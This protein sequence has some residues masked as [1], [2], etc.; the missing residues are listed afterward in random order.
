MPITRTVALVVTIG[1][2]LLVA[3]QWISHGRD[4]TDYPGYGVGLALGAGGAIVYAG[5]ILANVARVYC[6]GHRHGFEAGR[7]AAREEARAV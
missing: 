4:A 6:L 2:W 7:E 1:G 5:A 3:S